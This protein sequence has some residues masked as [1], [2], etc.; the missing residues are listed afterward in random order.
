MEESERDVAFF[1]VPESRVLGSQDITLKNLFD[2]GEVETMLC[3][4]RIAFGLRPSETAIHTVYTLRI[5]VKV[6]AHTWAQS[7]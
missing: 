2:V 7:S 3:K 1:A 5:Y 6:R 4:V